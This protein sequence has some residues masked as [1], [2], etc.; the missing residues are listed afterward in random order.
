[1]SN[2]SEVQVDF[3]LQSATVTTMVEYHDV[4]HLEYAPSEHVRLTFTQRSEW[5]GDTITESEIVAAVPPALRHQ[6]VHSSRLFVEGRATNESKTRE[7]SPAHQP[8]FW[9]HFPAANAAEKNVVEASVVHDV[10]LFARKLVSGKS[11]IPV[12]D[13]S[14]SEKRLC[15]ARTP[16][17]DFDSR[18]FQSFLREKALLR[19]E[20]ESVLAFGKRVHDFVFGYMTYKIDADM[21][22]TTATRDCRS[23]IGHCGNYAR[24]V[25]AIFRANSIPART[26][27]G[28]WAVAGAKNSTGDPHTRCDFWIP[29]V[30]WVLCDANY[31]NTFGDDDGRFVTFHLHGPL[32]LPSA[33][34]GTNRQYHL[35]GIY[36]PAVGGKWE[37]NRT[38]TKMRLEFLPL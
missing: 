21:E 2:S 15:L 26:H 25:T 37:H 38:T 23:R 31:P 36:M 6:V 9:T 5:L 11:P 20:D 32:L 17:M 28:H 19:K 27:F 10:T 29:D 30:G 34:W 4:W 16:E 7:L 12:P 8:I 14:S 3:V 1:M 35:Q 18:K 13:L 24:L 22:G 33:N